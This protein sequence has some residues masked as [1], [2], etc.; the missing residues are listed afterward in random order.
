VHWA[1]RRT[2]RG[3]RGEVIAEELITKMVSIEVSA[4]SSGRHY[5][6]PPIRRTSPS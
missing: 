5:G 4:W 2:V 1:R 3:C 6:R